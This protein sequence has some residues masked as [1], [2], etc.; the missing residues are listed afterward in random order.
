MTYRISVT[1]DI[2]EL[3][4]SRIAARSSKLG[5]TA[6]GSTDQ[7]AVANY[8]KLMISVLNHKARSE[9]V[10]DYLDRRGIDWW[11]DDDGAPA[12]DP[13]IVDRGTRGRGAVLV[14]AA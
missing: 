6:Y 11:R 9:A 2:H 13:Q 7:E 3:G 4:E 14:V 5:L 8:K 1:V 10:E 12:P